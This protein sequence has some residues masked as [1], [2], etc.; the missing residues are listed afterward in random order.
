MDFTPSLQPKLTMALESRILFIYGVTFLIFFLL[1][2]FLLGMCLR[3]LWTRIQP[4]KSAK[5][6]KEKSADPPPP[7]WEIVRELPRRTCQVFVMKKDD[8]P[9]PYHIAIV[10]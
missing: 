8:L 9:P 6:E 4:K 3:L 2:C 1:T 7:V 10:S 5:Q